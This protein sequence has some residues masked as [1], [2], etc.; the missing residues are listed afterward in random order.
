MK[1][2][3]KLE[4]TKFFL[5]LLDALEKRGESLTNNGDT[6]KEA[7]YI[8]SAILN[9]FYSV[10]ELAK[11]TNKEKVSDIKAF[12]KD[13]PIIYAGSGKGG[14]RNT[15]VHVKHINI[16]HSG[17][18]PP[19]GNEINFNYKKKPKLIVEEQNNTNDIKINLVPYFYIEVD[20]S[21]KRVVELADNHYYELN[22]FISGL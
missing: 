17:Y 11:E 3:E 1:T 22:N 4:E 6:E 10:T 5:E 2:N 21:M 16:D 7:S 15:T 14:L 20:K 18:I 13:N 8:L 12:K 19:K 9:G